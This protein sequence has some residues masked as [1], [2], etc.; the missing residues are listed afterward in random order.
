MVAARGVPARVA[1]AV[2]NGSGC[3]GCPGEGKRELEDAFPILVPVGE[4]PLHQTSEAARYV[5]AETH[6][7]RQPRRVMG[8]F[9]GFEDPFPILF[10]YQDGESSKTLSPSWYR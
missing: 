10:R 3:A 6:R 4:V 5:E 7:G 9:V 1:V 8:A 2:V